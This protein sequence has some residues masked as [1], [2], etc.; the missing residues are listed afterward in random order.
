MSEPPGEVRGFELDAHLSF[1]EPLTRA[2]AERALA[3]WG[4]PTTLYGLPEVRSARLT[5]PLDPEDVRRL[6]Q[7][8]LEGGTLRAAEVGRRGF[9][10]APDGRT[11]YMP[12]TR[13]KVLPR[14]QWAQVALEDGVKY[15][16][17]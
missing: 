2:Q 4:L 7:V 15:L 14:Q 5:G 12:W 16:L 8:G 13:N 3:A 6:L 11:E 10:R 17:E 1:R 9:L